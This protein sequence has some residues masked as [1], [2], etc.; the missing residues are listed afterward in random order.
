MKKTRGDQNG[1][2]PMESISIHRQA[3]PLPYHSFSKIPQTKLTRR[4]VV[5]GLRRNVIIVG[6]A[7]HPHS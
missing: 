2:P 1:H 7:V 6:K 4:I 5:P 3:E